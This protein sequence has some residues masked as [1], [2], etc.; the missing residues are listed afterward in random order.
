MCA[1]SSSR[2]AHEVVYVVLRN[3]SWTAGTSSPSL[4]WRSWCFQSRGRFESA[5]VWAVE[6]YIPLSCG[7]PGGGAQGEGHTSPPAGRLGILTRPD[8]AR[9]RPGAPDPTRPGRAC[10]GFDIGSSIGQLGAAPGSPSA[11]RGGTRAAVSHTAEMASGSSAP[12]LVTGVAVLSRLRSPSQTDVSWG[13]I[14]CYR[15]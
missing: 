11:T 5:A 14:L 1:E 2:V 15:D 12:L 4:P 7:R 9:P 8:P 10:A 13:R 6:L 3:S